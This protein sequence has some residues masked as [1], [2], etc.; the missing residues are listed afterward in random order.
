MRPVEFTSTRTTSGECFEAGEFGLAVDVKHAH[1]SFA[2]TAELQEL[3]G[4]KFGGGMD[5]AFE[6]VHAFGMLVV[7]FAAVK[8]GEAMPNRLE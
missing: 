6:A 8:L 3:G 2:L 5:V 1:G 4:G 7:H